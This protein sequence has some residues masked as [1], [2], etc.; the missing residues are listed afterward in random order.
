ME[1]WAGSITVSVPL[2][3]VA[4]CNVSLLCTIWA[5]RGRELNND[6]IR[7][8]TVKALHADSDVSNCFTSFHC[9][10]ILWIHS[11]NNALQHNVHY[12]TLLVTDDNNIAHSMLLYCVITTQ[13]S[14]DQW[15][16]HA[17]TLALL[18]WFFSALK[19]EHSDDCYC[20]AGFTILIR[21][22]LHVFHWLPHP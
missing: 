5:K 17:C 21:P 13:G 9:F 4:P 11:M 3:R 7:L 6:S 8:N 2:H 14:L 15:P 1:R 18:N 19:T 10:N 22:H 20:S 16:S 12:I